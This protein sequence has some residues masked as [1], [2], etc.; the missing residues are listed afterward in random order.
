MPEQTLR[1]VLDGE[2]D[3]YVNYLK[4]GPILAIVVQRENGVAELLRVV[5]SIRRKLQPSQRTSSGSLVTM[6]SDAVRFGVYASTS[7]LR[8]R[9]Q[10]EMLFGNTCVEAETI[11]VGDRVCGS[12]LIPM[13]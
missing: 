11:P 12:S 5:E 9:S 10:K 1:K 6:N 4:T 13:R 7:F 8:A 3:R 2:D